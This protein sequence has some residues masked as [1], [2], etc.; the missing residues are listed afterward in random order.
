MSIKGSHCRNRGIFLTRCDT[1][2]FPGP[3]VMMT[4]EIARSI[5]GTSTP[6]GPMNFDALS[7]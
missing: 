2:I 3:I 6:S 7:V 1:E 4:I 5:I